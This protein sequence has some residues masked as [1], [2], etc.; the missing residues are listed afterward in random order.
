M[1]QKTYSPAVRAW[2]AR[3]AREAR[4]QAAV[5]RADRL[6]SSEWRRI[7]GK[8]RALDALRE[9]AARFER[10]A[11]AEAVVDEPVPF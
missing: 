8:M 10:I 6:P 7:R 11:R 5:I 4:R 9:E 3:K 2:A 1:N